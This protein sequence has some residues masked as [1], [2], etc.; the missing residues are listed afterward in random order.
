MFTRAGRAALLDRRAFTEAFFDDD[1]AADGAIMVALVGAVTYLGTLLF[2]GAFRFFSLTTLLQTV[3]AAVASWLILAFATWFVATRLFGASNR[4][5]TTIAMQGLSVLPLLLEAF[6][7]FDG[8]GA[9]LAGGGLL[10]YLVVLTV[11]TQEATELEVRKS[12]V[13]VMIGFAAAALLRA[14]IGVPFAVLGSLFG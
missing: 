2:L 8:F 10:W 4:P 5:Q 14:L 13:S 1:A 11:A 9:W 3:I 12:A 7:V 6:G